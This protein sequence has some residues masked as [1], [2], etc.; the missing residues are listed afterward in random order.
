[1]EILCRGCKQPFDVEDMPLVAVC[2]ACKRRIGQALRASLLERLEAGRR[3]LEAEK[4]A[5]KKGRP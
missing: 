4:A 5:R 2:P 1:M 3:E